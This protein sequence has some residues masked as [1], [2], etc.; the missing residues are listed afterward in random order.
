M[1]K[2][3]REE[4]IT[5]MYELHDKQDKDELT[6]KSYEEYIVDFWIARETA[7]LEE[8]LEGFKQIKECSLEPDKIVCICDRYKSIIQKRKGGK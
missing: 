1:T 2:D 8:M 6:G 5:A 3:I 4:L 7:M